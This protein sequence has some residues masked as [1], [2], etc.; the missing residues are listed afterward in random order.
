MAGRRKEVLWRR[1][2]ERESVERKE[3]KK[4][5]HGLSREIV[6]KESKKYSS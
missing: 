3:K 4:N 2:I 1:E 5:S 6:H